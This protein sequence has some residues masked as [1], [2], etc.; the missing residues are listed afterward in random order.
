MLNSNKPIKE[1]LND[2]LCKTEKLYYKQVLW[3]YL[4]EK[5]PE[6]KLHTEKNFQ[7]EFLLP[8]L[9]AFYPSW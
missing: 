3:A 2:K 1:R 5:D 9:K 8:Q 6:V 7:I 4:A